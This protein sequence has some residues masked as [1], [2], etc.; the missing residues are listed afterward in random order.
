MLQDEIQIARAK[1]WATLVI[2]RADELCKLRANESDIAVKILS[3]E[4]FSE[5][6]DQIALEIKS[7]L[8]DKMLMPINEDN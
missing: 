5:A 1:N 8:Y 7:G 6:V 3:G 4:I 2:N